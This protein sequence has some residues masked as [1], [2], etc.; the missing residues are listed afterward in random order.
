MNEKEHEMTMNKRKKLLEGIDLCK[1]QKDQKYKF[2]QVSR[3]T[4]KPEDY[5]PYTHGDHIERQRELMNEELKEDLVYRLTQAERAKSAAS[6]QFRSLQ[7]PSVKHG[8]PGY[9]NNP[10]EIGSSHPRKHIPM[11]PN[12]EMQK[13]KQKL[14]Q[15]FLNE[16]PN[17]L[18]DHK[19]VKVRAMDP[20]KQV[21]ALELARKRFEDQLIKDQI[22]E[23]LDQ[24]DLKQAINESVKYY[25][26]L[27]K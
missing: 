8:D 20:K 19:T 6:S 1:A 25:E 18:K 11:D 14:E 4:Q 17:Y 7:A 13:R 27:D 24:E 15:K 9:V 2:E 10:E 21:E 23:Q 12:P 16:H 5:F 22:K 26:E 3:L